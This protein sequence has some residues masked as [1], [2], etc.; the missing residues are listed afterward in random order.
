[1]S[2]DPSLLA[3]LD[4]VAWDS[5]EH[6][7]GPAADVPEV[8]RALVSGDDELADEAMYELYGNIWHQG[9]VYPATVPAVPFLVA[10]AVAGAAGKQTPEV[11]RL[12]GYLAA[13]TD[14]RGVEDRDAVR[15][16][17]AEHVDALTGLLDDADART[18]AA[19]MFVL[20]YAGSAEDARPLIIER[21]RTDVEALSRAEALNALMRVDPAAAAD[22]G[23]EVLSA[24]ARGDSPD[25]AVLRVSCALAWTSA[26]R[27]M[28]DRVLAAA[29]TPIPEGSGLWYWND[30][31]DLFDQLINAL[32]ER[33]GAQASVELLIEALAR[34]ADVP[35]AQA[36]RYLYA[37]RQLIVAYRSAPGLLAVPIAKLLHRPELSGDVIAVLSLIDPALVTSVGRDRLV[38]LAQSDASPHSDEARLADD[39]LACL[40]RG[41]DPIVP[42]LLARALGARPQ[43]I[44][45]VTKPTA[46]LPFDAGLLDAIRRRLNDIC[47]AAQEPSAETGNPFIDVQNRAEPGELVKILK[48]WGDQAA[49]AVPELIRLLQVRPSAAA[50]LLAALRPQSLEGMAQ[51]R[52]IAATAEGGDAIYVRLAA[53]RAIRTLTA[54]AGP[55]LAAVVFGLTTESKNPDERGPAAEAASDLPDHADVLVPL[56]LQA[57][58]DIPVPTPSLPAHQAR[59]DIGRALWALTGQPEPAIDVLRSTLG[60]A[61][62]MF[63]AWKVA[64]AADVAADI[65]PAARGLVPSLEAALADPVSC[66]AAVHALLTVDPGGPWATSRREEL[67]DL[68]FGVLVAGAS[69]MACS[70]AV[71]VLATLAPLPAASVEKLRAIADRDER[72]PIRVLDA[73]HLHGDDV[74]QERIQALIG[75]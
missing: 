6:A 17:V 72:L 63:T 51:L 36:A 24:A 1:M 22:L 64:A 10:I 21:W 44:D 32:A 70:R 48:N 8:L 52:R 40:A 60:L 37:A 28:N 53:A 35:T 14:P 65:G 68:L 20:V 75:G 42:G 67:A 49:P 54:D 2:F 56:L 73:E 27:A 12:L 5:L 50:P 34:S 38:E 25:D 57:L 18:R 33:H 7:Y 11:L 13:S 71:D 61:G 39:A 29:L 9:S 16:A 3:G 19:A 4:D 30:D 45:I 43:T 66:P 59:I 31:G 47:D 58:A 62:E 69:S 15:S 23:D 74:L 55:L 41:N 46:A 26:G